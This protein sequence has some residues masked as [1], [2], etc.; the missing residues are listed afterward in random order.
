MP[1]YKAAIGPDA[2]DM[3]QRAPL[4]I[5]WVSAQQRQH[6]GNILFTSRT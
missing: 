2:E 6:G 5:E 3:R 4:A 1:G